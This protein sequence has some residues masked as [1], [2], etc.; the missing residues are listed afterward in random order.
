MARE[1]HSGIA[2]LYHYYLS[3]DEGG[4]SANNQL[5]QM[6]LEKPE[7]WLGAE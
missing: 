7:Q 1:T 4:S 6:K 5:E 2:I 3:M